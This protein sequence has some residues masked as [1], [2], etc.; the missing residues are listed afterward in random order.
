MQPY[1]KDVSVHWVQQEDDYPT[2]LDPEDPMDRAR[3]EAFQR[4]EWWL[5]R[6]W[7]QAT[8]ALEGYMSPE[9]EEVQVIYSPGNQNVGSDISPR[10]REELEDEELAHLEHRLRV[11][12]VDTASLDKLVH[13]S[14][15]ALCEGISL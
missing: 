7:A 4:E 6:V 9:V 13:R 10:I 11:F 5:E 15:A 1:L 3:L 12:G 14:S 2:F 8:V